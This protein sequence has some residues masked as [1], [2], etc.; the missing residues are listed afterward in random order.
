MRWGWLALSAGLAGQVHAMSAEG[1]LLTSSASLTYASTAGV[2]Y[3]MSYAATANALVS[4]PCITVAQHS[5]PMVA[6]AGGLVQFSIAFSNCSGFASSYNL[7]AT[8]LVPDNM[9]Y[10]G[11]RE[12]LSPGPGG[13]WAMSWKTPLSPW[14]N[15]PAPTGQGGPVYL[16]WCLTMLGIGKTAFVGYGARIR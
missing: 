2:P 1:L 16:R 5:D 9:A 12:V 8:E 4:N 15:G 10:A 13:V 3:E 6:N 14:T 11:G 7:V